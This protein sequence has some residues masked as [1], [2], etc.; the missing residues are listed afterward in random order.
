M[1]G[2]VTP[3]AAYDLVK[4]LKESV[5]IP[6]QLHTHYTS[7]MA[8]MA[9]IKAV[10]AGV[11]IVDTAMSPLAMG[12]SHAPTESIVAAFKGTPYD[13]G[14]D[15]NKLNVVRE[16]CATLREKILPTAC[17]VPRCWASTPT[18]CFTRYPA[19]CFPT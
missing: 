19:A 9:I 15:L 5:K 2:L 13:T 1:A 6:I 4:A 17:S 18:P 12:T 16:Y 11:D 14:L 7:G 10:E 8:S 3:Y